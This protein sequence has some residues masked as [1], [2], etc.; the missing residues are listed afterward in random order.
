MKSVRRAILSNWLPERFLGG[1]AESALENFLLYID[2]KSSD[3]PRHECFIINNIDHIYSAQHIKET[4]L[5]WGVKTKLAILDKNNIQSFELPA[6]IH[7]KSSGRYL[8]VINRDKKSICYI[9]TTRGIKNIPINDFYQLLGSM[10]L[11]PLELFRFGTAEQEVLK[12]KKREAKTSFLQKVKEIP[13]LINSSTCHE[14]IE[15]AATKLQRSRVTDEIGAVATVP[16]RTSQSAV[17]DENNKSV[18]SVKRKVTEI[19]PDIKLS[20]IE[21]LQC[22]SYGPGQFYKPHF[23]TFVSTELD[24]QRGLT[25]LIYLNDNYKGGHTHFPDLLQSF[26]PETGKALIFPLLTS[27]GQLERM[28][29]HAGLPVEEGRKFAL[30]IW[31]RHDP[32]NL[33]FNSG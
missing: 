26:E 24:Q 16:E 14:L 8:V 2:K 29:L 17:L 18:H 20:Q 6:I 4:L 5:K 1:N 22:V 7:H 12:N 23:D 13:N 31:I 21:A 25:F 11:T 32:N 10:L 30:N 3:L 27:K 9:D 33:N 19:F 28:A 15:H